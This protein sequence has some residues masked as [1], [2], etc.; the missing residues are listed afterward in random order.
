MKK[1]HKIEP[2]TDHRLA[3]IDVVSSIGIQLMRLSIQMEEAPDC[4]YGEGFTEDLATSS[5][6]MSLVLH[7]VLEEYA[8][9]MDGLFMDLPEGVGSIRVPNP[10]YDPNEAQSP[11]EPGD[12]AQGNDDLFPF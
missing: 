11:D 3:L 12:V 7:K 4:V 5:Y 6:L 9:L 10:L 2:E 1:A 8:W